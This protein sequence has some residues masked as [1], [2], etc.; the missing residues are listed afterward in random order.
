M[1]KLILSAS[2]LLILEISIAQTANDRSKV[3]IAPYSICV[4]GLIEKDSLTVD[5]LLTAGGIECTSKNFKVVEFS[6]SVGDGNCVGGEGMVMSAICY[7]DRFSQNATALLT[8]VQPGHHVFI[9][10]VKV[11]TKNDQ[12]FALKTRILT[13]IC[14]TLRE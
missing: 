11:K 13:I 3:I 4:K 1:S 7:G 6:V 12:V 5:E 2:L 10:N 8:R 14:K 9:E